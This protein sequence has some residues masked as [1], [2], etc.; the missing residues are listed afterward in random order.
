[1]SEPTLDNIARSFERHLRA[2]N[3]SPK[4]VAT[5]MEAVR[6]LPGHL[7]ESGRTLADARRGDVEA[8]LGALLERWSAATA[9]NRYRALKVF[10]A[11]MEDEGEVTD[12]PMRRMKPPAVPDKPVDVL[13]EEHLRRLLAVCASR[14]FKARRDTALI[15]LLLDSGG[16]LAE[17]S[18]MHVVDVDFELDVAMVL[19]K[20]RRER[21]LPFGQK[22]GV[23][24]DR[25]LRVRAR[26]AHA[27]LDWLW[28]GE[29]GRLSPSGVA[30]MLLRRGRE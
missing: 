30:Q 10:Y 13:T 25:Y 8:F 2:G 27:G 3:K 7:G 4:T 23:A 14:D 21:A 19:G 9:S 15:M 16:R 24:I 11:W 26:H 6:Q 1:M 5:Y 20:G 22:T 18:E 17:I 12:N 29:R 28:L